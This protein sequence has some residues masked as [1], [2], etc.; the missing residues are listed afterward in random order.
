MAYLVIC[1]NCG[2]IQFIRRK[3]DI[4]DAIEY[5]Q[6][7]SNCGNSFTIVRIP[8]KLAI[9]IR[10]FAEYTKWQNEFHGLIRDV[11]RISTLVSKI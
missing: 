7:V 9:K 4:N 2:F 6:V 10:E 5:H 11:K 3:S 1:D 8:N